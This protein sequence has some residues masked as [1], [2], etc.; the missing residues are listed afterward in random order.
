MVELFRSNDP[1]HL[2]WA[3]AMLEAEGIDCLLVDAHISAIEGSIGAF[4]R[5]LL[6]RA[7]D[8]EHARQILARAAEA[9]LDDHLP[10]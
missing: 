1:V 8:L 5:R 2:S 4:P 9:E 7:R 10:E 3:M 6:V